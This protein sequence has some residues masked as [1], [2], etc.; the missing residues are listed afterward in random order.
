MAAT[1]LA[2][3][4]SA[5]LPMS[6]FPYNHFITYLCGFIEIHVVVALK[7]D[8]LERVD[9]DFVPLYRVVVVAQLFIG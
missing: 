2:L 8:L 7:P 4:K 1:A 9:V 5:R 6:T 3:A